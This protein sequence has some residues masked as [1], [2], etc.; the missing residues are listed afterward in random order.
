MTVFADTLYWVAIA[1]PRDS[2]HQPAKDA[3][4]G[5]GESQIVTSDGVLSEFLTALASGGS[6][7]RQRAVAVVRNILEDPSV[8]V[9]PQT[10]QAFLDGMDLYVSR[11]DKTYSL[12]DCMSMNAMRDE[13]ISHILTNDHHFTQEGFSVLIQR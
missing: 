7:L 3:K 12:V 8:I 9:L 4:Q 1:N 6:H 5:L 10:H 13:D 2:W 11:P